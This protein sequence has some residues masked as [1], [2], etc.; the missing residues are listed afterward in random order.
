M[1]AAKKGQALNNFFNHV[2][3]ALDKGEWVK[4]DLA[5][6]ANLPQHLKRVQIN[7]TSDYYVPQ[8]LN[9]LKKRNRDVM[10]EIL[11]VFRQAWGN[12]NKWMLHIL[13][14][15]PLILDHIDTLK[16]MKHMVQVEVSFA[17]G[18]E[19]L[20]RSLEYFTPSIKKRLELVESLAKA[21]LFVRI[22][23]MP[24]YGD[25][26]SLDELKAEAFRHGAKAFKNKGINYYKWTDVLKPQTF[27]EFIRDGIPDDEGR[28]DKKDES[29]IVKSGEFF[30]VKR[31]P[32]KKTVLMPK[33]EFLKGA[34]W[35]AHTL[36]SERLEGKPMKVID[37]GYRD[38]N[39]VD[40][41]YIR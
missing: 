38:C 19:S 12:G 9:E 22:M 25:A 39:A 7:E 20:S 36:T 14:K 33:D 2:E 37:C 5:N 40:W 24:F 1:F 30:Q 21:G 8:V 4:E 29:R 41:G 11:N 18:D 31:K 34:K 26:N 27:E 16:A 32:I 3:V 6:F 35:A 28:M 17:T 10:L 15:S 23:A 13:T